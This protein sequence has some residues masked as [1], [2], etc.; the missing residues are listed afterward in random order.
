M[1]AASQ[2]LVVLLVGLFCCEARDLAI[3]VEWADSSSLPLLLLLIMSSVVVDV[4]D[5]LAE[6]D[7]AEICCTGEGVAVP[8]E[9]N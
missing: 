9:W 7:W 5:R 2:V 4:D 3:V 1:F 8:Y 6:R